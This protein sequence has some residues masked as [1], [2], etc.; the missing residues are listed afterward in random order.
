MKKRAKKE[1]GKQVQ[2]EISSEPGS[3]VYLAGTFND[4]N[5]NAHPL[6]GK[7]DSEHFTTTVFIPVGTHEYKFVVNGVWRVDPNCAAWVP[8]DQG[9]LN[10]VVHV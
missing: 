8:N 2:F 6:N 4:W 10:S 5:P 1:T 7:P 3:Q 9:S